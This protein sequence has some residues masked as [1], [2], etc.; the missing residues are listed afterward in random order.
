[1]KADRP[2]PVAGLPPTGG[3]WSQAVV[4]GN[5]VAVSGQVA[6]DNAGNVVGETLAEQ[7]EHV[8]GAVDAALAAAG[9]SRSGLLKITMFVTTLDG[10]AE[11]RASRDRWLG[12]SAPASTLVQVV[13]LVRPELLIEVEAFA[14]RDD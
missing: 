10:L 14:I 8:F 11:L 3:S 1:V 9:S 5:L 2:L 7:A 13:G 6:L 12:E 4:W